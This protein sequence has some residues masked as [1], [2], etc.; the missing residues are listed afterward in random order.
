MMPVYLRGFHL[1]LSDRRSQ[2]CVA[3]GT[4]CQ[5]FIR[6]VG[7]GL[8]ETH[9]IVQDD[10]QCTGSHRARCRNTGELRKSASPR[11]VGPG[12]T[13]SIEQ[14]QKWLIFSYLTN[15]ELDDTGLP[16]PT[17]EVDQERKIAIYDLLE[18][19][20]FGLPDKG[21]TPSLAGPYRLTLSIADKRLV[22]DVLTD[23]GEKAAEFPFVS[24]AVS[25]HHQRL[26]PDLRSL[27]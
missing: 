10:P 12:T 2:S 24:V 13:G 11:T 26:L 4:V 15:I 21:D 7:F 5:I 18:D 6:F 23:Q 14:R 27:F 16:A 3:D 1:C 8:Y 20:V 19:N 25:R 9:N 22:F 17:P